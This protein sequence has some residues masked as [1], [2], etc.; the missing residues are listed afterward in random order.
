MVVV[1]RSLLRFETWTFDDRCFRIFKRRL[2]E[3]RADNPRQR[4][5]LVKRRRR[6]QGPFESR[7]AASPG[8]G[9]RRRFAAQRQDHIDEEHKHADAEDVRAH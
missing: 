5:E 7:R 2:T 6:R 1:L 8:I 9:A 4:A 3:P